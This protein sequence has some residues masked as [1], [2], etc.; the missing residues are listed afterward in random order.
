MPRPRPEW[1]DPRKEK[2][3]RQMLRW[4]R[5]SGLTGRDFCAENGLS[6]PSFYGW[7]RE[8]ARR[9]QEG[10]ARTKRAVRSSTEQQVTEAR[11]AFM[12]VA[13]D[14]AAVA[15]AIEVIVGER[16]VLRVGP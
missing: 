2:H 1:R 10:A 5:R 6:E 14:G 8:L 15:S 9:D 13:I 16:R 12:R 7:K 3:W 11:P 4:W